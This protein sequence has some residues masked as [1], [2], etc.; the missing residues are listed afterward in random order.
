MRPDQTTPAPATILLAALSAA[1]LGWFVLHHLGRESFWYDE[2]M[3][4]WMSMGLDG[5]GPPL[6]TPRGLAGILLENARGNL[7]PGGF[8]L[9]VAPWQRLGTEPAWLRT[10]PMLFFVAGIAGLGLLGWTW[11]RSLPFAVAA[12]LVPAC[13]PMLLDHAMEYRAYSMEF[14]GIVLGS[15]A[16]ARLQAKPG[17]AR[18]ALAGCLFGLFL[19][20]RY[21]YA[22][23]TGAAGIA[24]AG[25]SYARDSVRSLRWRIWAA[26]ALPVALFGV[27][28]LVMLFLPQ[29]RARISF[30][31]GRLL[32]YLRAAMAV[33]KSP[34]ELLELAL[35]NLSRPA[36][37]PATLL[38]GVGLFA[39]MP[40]GWRARLGLGILSNETRLFGILA[41][42]ALALNAIAWRWHP[43]DVERKWSL[44]LHALS[45]V[46][47]VRL[48]A[49]AM[50]YMRTWTNRRR[51]RSAWVAA[52]C[53]AGI[54]ALDIRLATYRRP[55]HDNLLPTLAYLE[56]LRPAAGTVAVTGEWYPTLRQFYEYA[57]LAGSPVFP[58]AFRLPHWHGPQPLVTEA[59]RWIVT[60]H[61]PEALG[62][63]V[64]ARRILRDPALPR[65]LYRVAPPDTP[66]R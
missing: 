5:F 8:T 24:L 25:M 55:V 4:F 60:A 43:W 61:R 3:Q 47:I 32:D 33:G 66:G 52:L 62:D 18:A 15:L 13:F 50:P 57:P 10:V 9:L 1:A 16:L 30:E 54:L 17:I 37:I 21:S 58:S 49:M 29:Y 41:L 46:A 59:T 19:T 42:A 11:T 40:P 35:R 63:I 53:W 14:A 28:I 34:V 26:F 22:L 2:S 44:W 65:Y 27:A 23:F 56:T 39:L 31:G 12:A 20:S 51:G 48:A 6:Q 38:A 45:A 36:A 7:D 64:P